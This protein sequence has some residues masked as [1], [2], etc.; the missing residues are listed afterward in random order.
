MV[1]VRTSL[2]CSNGRASFAPGNAR[3]GIVA[4]FFGSAATDVDDF[5]S[6]GAFREQMFDYAAGTEAERIDGALV[7]GPTLALFGAT[8]L[9]G[10]LITPDD[11]RVGTARVAVI[12]AE[13]WRTRLAAAPDAVTRTARASNCG[14]AYASTHS[15]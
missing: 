2:C 7:T 15:L 14:S 9:Q 8:T 11:D 10:R 13:F 12:S 3:P 6:F 4:G 1:R 5:S